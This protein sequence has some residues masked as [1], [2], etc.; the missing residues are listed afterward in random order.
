MSTLFLFCMGDVC[1]Q[2][3]S[4]VAPAEFS[5]DG[6]DLE[7]LFG[8]AAEVG[9]LYLYNVGKDMFLNAGGYW[10]TQ[11]MT[12]TVGL[13]VTIAKTEKGYTISGPFSNSGGYGQGDYLGIVVKQGNEVEDGVYWDRSGDYTNW[14]F[15]KVT[16]GDGNIYTISSD[17]YY[18]QGN[19]QLL[20]DLLYTANYNAVHYTGEITDDEVFAQWK[21]VTEEDLTADFVNTYDKLHPANAT[22]LLRAQNF[23]RMNKYN[24]VENES[25]EG[26]HKRGSD[27][28][29]DCTVGLS[30]KQ[31]AE[32]RYNGTHGM[33]FNAGI[34]NA[35]E[36]DELFQTV[37]V[38]VPGWYR[39]DCQ[40][41]FYNSGDEDVCNARMFAV[42]DGA[43]E[44]A[45]TSQN[46]YI[47]LLPKKQ[48]ETGP[49]DIDNGKIDDRREAGMSFYYG[50]YPNSLLVYVDDVPENGTR[51][52][53]IGIRITKDMDDG[54][55]Y[56]WFD[57]FE[58]RY[59]GAE[60]LLD[61]DDTSFDTDDDTDYKN[62]VLVLK[63][64]MKPGVWN[65]LVLPVDLTKQQ[66]FTAFFPNPRIAELSGI[67][68]PNTI[69]F[70]ALDIKSMDEDDTALHKGHCYIIN[71]GF[72]GKTGSYTVHTGTGAEK[73]ITGPYY[74]IDRVSL[75]KSEVTDAA[76][77]EDK[78]SG[79]NPFGPF[80]Y[81]GG[82]TA[83]QDCSIRFYGCY[84]ISKV[85]ANSYVFSEGDIYHITKEMNIKGFRCW[86]EDAHQMSPSAESRHVLSFS[87][88]G[89]ADST[90][91]IEGLS[92]AWEGQPCGNNVVYNL[93]GQAV[94][95]GSPSLECLP[96]GVYIVNGRKY[97]V[98]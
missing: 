35:V 27:F 52:L 39:L 88:N 64:Y 73:N 89:V 54:K 9:K 26:W 4:D 60:I 34:T 56:T 29:Y 76:H 7:E 36:G 47:D 95:T 3:E 84:Q 23:N 69:S 30:D 53:K 46:S 15:E 21:I 92:V 41:F 1:A 71:P 12:Y 86:I 98:N 85:G 96:K 66:L 74:L 5:G 11:A 28:T 10:G 44:K 33:F 40:G 62:R 20:K 22:F 77:V 61:E 67:E 83:N 42:V 94:R 31:D 75:K 93:N 70:T 68:K 80:E 14:T 58:L 2:N 51:K 78:D 45:N 19:H 43:E 37:E 38:S 59:L 90:T 25:G 50:Y 91:G 13:P 97:V 82:G 87:I 32:G 8:E 17:G 72:E 79:G 65:A 24:Y 49:S 16:S 57:N 18:L 81:N 48:K 6:E 55:D 63:R